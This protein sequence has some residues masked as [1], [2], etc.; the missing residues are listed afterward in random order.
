M[1]AQM[2]QSIMKNFMKSRSNITAQFSL[3]KTFINKTITINEKL[4]ISV[5]MAIYPKTTSAQRV[6]DNCRA[7]GYVAIIWVVSKA[8]KM[9][10]AKYIIFLQV[11]KQVVC[12]DLYAGYWGGLEGRARSPMVEPVLFILLL[13]FELNFYDLGNLNCLLY[14]ID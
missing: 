5:Q 8:M 6:K 2:G 14:C 11:V 9:K 12:L 10:C 13:F 1:I 7:W 4:I 3:P